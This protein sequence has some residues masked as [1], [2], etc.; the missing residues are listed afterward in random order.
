[1]SHPVEP[2]DYD[3]VSTRLLALLDHA[4]DAA[5]NP[6]GFDDLFTMADSFFFPRSAIEGVADDIL[7]AG[8][9]SV[10]MDGHI[11]RLQDLIDRSEVNMAG[12]TR[13][14]GGPQLANLVVSA[15]GSRIV[16]NQAAV[17][18]LQCGFPTSLDRLSL[19]PLS[20]ATLR[21]CLSDLRQG[22]FEG[23]TVIPFQHMEQAKPYLAKCTKLQSRGPDGTITRGL[24][25]TINHVDWRDNTLSYAAETFQLTPAENELLA[26]FLDGMT[27]PE[28]AHHLGKSRE[29]LKVQSKSILRKT[30]A[31]QMSDIV[32]L[33]M[34]YAFLAEPSKFK[35]TEDS[36]QFQTQGKHD[37]IVASDGRKIQVNRFG[38]RGGRPLIFFHGLYQGPYLSPFLDAAFAKLGIEVFAPSRPGFNRTDPPAQWDSFNQVTTEDVM[39]LCSHFGIVQTDF[40]VHQA[41]ISFACRAAGAMSGRV[42]AAVMIGAGVPIKDYM[43]KTMNTEARVAG[44]AVKYAPKLLDMLLRLGIAKWRRQGSY[45]YLNNLFAEGQPDRET[46]NDPE[47]GPIMEKG[48]LHMISQGSQTIIHDGLSAMGDWETEYPKL[49]QRQLWLHGAHDHVMNHRF[50][51]EFLE[52]NGQAAPVIYPD[53]GGDVLLGA[54]GDVM[55]RIAEFLQA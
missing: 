30:G 35:S 8:D 15:D 4:Y 12:G 25:I 26:C 41:G 13:V 33:M 20:Q 49:P 47:T 34:S 27:T 23:S 50:V 1:M 3:P 6:H 5:E 55:Q 46:L 44:A 45:A 32:H 52:A 54:S 28:A 19:M 39:T 31:P 43:L 40:I 22:H 18:L 11:K 7:Q 29:T 24:S 16:G 9:V 21:A 48:I 38:L 36:P 10:G 2:S 14:S 17:N 37:L 42:G 53:R 51:E